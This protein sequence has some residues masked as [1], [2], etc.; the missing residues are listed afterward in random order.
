MYSEA[1]MCDIMK[2]LLRALAFM[3]SNRFIHKDLKPQNIMLVEAMRPGD[4]RASIKVID[5]GLAELF[6]GDQTVSREVGGTLLYMAPEMFKQ[7]IAFK[8]DIWSSG[9][10][11]YQMI[12]GTYPFIGKWPLPPGK[13]MDWWQSETRRLVETDSIRMEPHP[14][15]SDP[16]AS[17]PE[18]RELLEAMLQKK[19]DIRP[20]A[21]QCLTKK[22][23]EKFGESPPPLSIGMTQCLEAYTVQPDLKKAIFLLM[24][25]SSTA[26]ALQELRAVFTHF[27]TQNKGAL[28]TDVLRDVLRKSRLDPLTVE[29]VLEALDRDGSGSVQWTEFMAAALCVANSKRKDIIQAAFNTCDRDG[30]GRVSQ[31][32]LLDVFASAEDKFAWKSALPTQCQ[33]LV[34][35]GAAIPS[36]FTL[37]HF[38]DSMTEHMSCTLGDRLGA[39]S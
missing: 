24:A 21:G 29:R 34:K 19:Q 8:C 4:A 31:A 25:H 13:T 26:P 16:S 30:D 10:I 27:D 38:M 14:R 6:K 23:F 22:W 12:T 11:L 35:S 5:F 28:G 2:Q 36:Q 9:V 3:H 32:D 39:V 17:S 20:D 37:D 33:I 18:A 7:Q 1:W 15:L